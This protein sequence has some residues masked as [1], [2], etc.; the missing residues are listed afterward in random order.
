MSTASAIESPCSIN[1]FP[2]FGRIFGLPVLATLHGITTTLEIGLSWP[3][4]SWVSTTFVPITWVS[5]VGAWPDTTLH[6]LTSRFRTTLSSSLFLISISWSFAFRSSAV[7]FHDFI[8]VLFTVFWWL[9]VPVVTQSDIPLK[10]THIT[11][12][13]FTTVIKMIHNLATICNAA[14]LLH[15]LFH[16]LVECF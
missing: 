11:L 5:K 16:L 15:C 6:E 7:V 3:A 9:L 12:D 13:V 8:I 1:L 4:T 2:H 10:L 14:N